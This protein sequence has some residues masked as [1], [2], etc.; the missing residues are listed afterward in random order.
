MKTYTEKEKAYWI[1]VLGHLPDW[2]D[3]ITTESLDYIR[4]QDGGMSEAS[5]G[6]MAA[7][8]HKAACDD[9]EAKIKAY[10]EEQGDDE[11]VVDGINCEGL[12]KSLIEPLIALLKQRGS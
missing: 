5:A 3:R 1:E 8:I 12:K 2:A 11:N 7:G 4:S 9:F 10:F 6:N